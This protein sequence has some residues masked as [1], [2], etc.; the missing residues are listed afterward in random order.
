[1]L[2]FPILPEEVKVQ[3]GA[4]SVSASIVYLGELKIP[5]GTS[6]TKYSWDSFL[7]GAQ[8]LASRC[9]HSSGGQG[10]G[11]SMGADG[12]SLA[13][14][15]RVRQDPEEILRQILYWVEN[16]NKLDLMITDATIHD[17]VFIQDF[18]YKPYGGFGDYKYSITLMQYREAALVILQTAADTGGSS[19][20]GSGTDGNGQYGLVTTNKKKGKIAVRKQPKTKSKKLGTIPNGSSLQILENLGSWYKIP[21]QNGQGYVLAKWV[22]PTGTIHNATETLREDRTT[23][24]HASTYTVQQGDTLYTIAKKQ[25]GSGT[26]Y[27]VIYKLN[28]KAID[29][30]NKAYNR[31]QNLKRKRK[32]NRYY[33]AP[34]MTLTLP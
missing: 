20:T 8:S 34:G 18:S 23:P 17:S 10:T 33:V 6:L 12:Q 15:I 24:D 26:R 1:M 21:Y 13:D 19:G 4:Q 30:A 9:M 5:R 32:V 2:Q 28:K 16:G 11:L 27:T 7:P 14:Y 25:L 31:E 22:L 29:K 3:A